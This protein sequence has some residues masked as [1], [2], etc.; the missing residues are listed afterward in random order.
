VASMST[1]RGEYTS[2]WVAG[3]HNLGPDLMDPVPSQH[4]EDKYVASLSTNRDGYTGNWVAGQHDL[5]PDL[6]IPV[7]PSPEL[8]SSAMG[9]LN[10]A[11]PS[12]E[13]IPS[14]LTAHVTHSI[15]SASEITPISPLLRPVSPLQ[16]TVDA[17]N[18]SDIEA[19]SWEF[20][21]PEQF[22]GTANI[23]IKSFAHFAVTETSCDRLFNANQM[24]PTNQGSNL[25][26]MA[27]LLHLQDPSVRMDLLPPTSPVIDGVKLRSLPLDMGS[28]GD[29]WQELAKVA[30]F[31]MINK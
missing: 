29:S 26:Y 24:K 16:I 6:S 17:E 15:D 8:I 20:K 4:L 22:S 23:Q 12:H 9:I 13:H 27:R 7:C 30:N 28:E 14:G 18:G 1:N 21:T 5:G 10:P 25:V 3:Q 19:K 31:F 2:N 11:P